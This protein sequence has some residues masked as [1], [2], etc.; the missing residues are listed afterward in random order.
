VALPSGLTN[1]RRQL[2]DEGQSTTVNGDGPYTI[3]QITRRYCVTERCVQI[4]I[5]SGELS[6]LNVSRYPG[7][8][9]PRWRI[10]RQALEAFERL[11]ATT[12]V[13]RLRRRQRRAEVME[14]IK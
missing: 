13:P 3:Q 2:E 7:S 12:P 14:F 11:R 4:W 1:H 6:A 5:A 10:T 8:K 9:K